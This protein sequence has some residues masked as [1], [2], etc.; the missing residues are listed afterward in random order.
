MSDSLK[1]VHLA[2]GDL[3]A[4]AEVQLYELAVALRNDADVEVEVVL[5][6][7][8]RLAEQL[9]FARVPVTVFDERALGGL[10]ILRAL[11]RYLRD[12]RPDV[13]HTHRQKENVLGSIAARL[14]GVRRS[15]RT[16]HGAPEF[17]AGDLRQRVNMRLDILS[18]QWLQHAIIM[19]TSELAGQ[20]SGRYPASRVRVIEN[21]I[22]RPDVLAGD[23]PQYARSGRINVCFAGRLVPVKRI[24]VF[25][26]IAAACAAANDAQ[27]HFHIFG[28]GP[29]ADEL[30][31]QVCTEGTD[32]LIS[33]W[34]FVDGLPAALAEMDVLVMT[35]S[36]EGLPM[37]ML[38]AMALG[39]PIV[40]HAVGGMVEVLDGGSAGV[41]VREHTPE[42]F[43][44]ALL[45]LVDPD[46][47]RRIADAADARFE[48]RY[49][50][51]ACA[52]RTA[53]LYRE[54]L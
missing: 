48:D 46:A 11:V 31:R 18:A 26:G 33:R 30:E 3:W 49:T 17:L 4:G 20:L 1:V 47:R 14:A 23:S 9:R 45:G 28:D 6:N 21:G 22:A 7:E 36:H 53:E 24:D 43:R 8:G 42:A 39:V 50:A 54:I 34:G 32:E 44:R 10:A 38:E 25:A 13:V 37:V 29:L 5:L 35:S 12:S 27:F 40:A 19:V 52:A 2:S 41:L 16:V 15:V 51:R